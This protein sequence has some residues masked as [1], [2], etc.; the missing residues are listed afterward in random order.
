MDKEKFDLTHQ[1]VLL[2]ANRI[3]VENF[4]DN[5]NHEK[6]NTILDIHTA[7]HILI[8]NG[9]PDDSGIDDND[10]NDFLKEICKDPFIVSIK[11]K[12]KNS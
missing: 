9:L 7:L 4:M 2:A 8:F 10:L 1:K 11:K 3:A 5:P 6:A 12:K